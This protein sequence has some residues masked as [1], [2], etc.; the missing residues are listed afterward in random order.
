M[1]SILKTAVAVAALM[2]VAFAA[3][4]SAAT[5][6]AAPGGTGLDPCQSAAAPC[7]IFTA[8]ASTAPRTTVAAGDEVI[9]APGNYSDLAGDLGPQRF[10]GLKPGIAL[11]GLAGLPRPEIALDGQGSFGAIIV[12][13]GNSV[14]HLEFT[15]SNIAQ[16]AFTMEAGTVSDVIARS[17]APFGITCRQHGGTIR[18]SVC[19][20]SGFT[21]AAVGSEFSA[22]PGE[23]FTA[24]LRSVTAISTGPG[25][26]GVSYGVAGDA[27]FAID[28]IGVIARATAQDVIA[29]AF[30]VAP[31]TPGT[32]AGV[33]IALEHSAFGDSGTASDAGLGAPVVPLPGSGTNIAAAPLLA[34]DGYHQ[35]P[36]SPTVDSGGLDGFEIGHDIDGDSRTIGIAG[37]IGADELSGLETE[38]RLSCSPSGVTI[39]VAVAVTCTA[40]VA[41]TSPTPDSPTGNVR[42]DVD[43]L[44]GSFGGNATCALVAATAAES[45]C[46]VA[47]LPGQ[48]AAGAHALSAV[49]R[50]DLLHSSSLGTAVVMVA[51]PAGGGGMAMA[52]GPPARPAAPQTRL[53]KRPAAKTTRRLA[54]FSFASDQAGSR[55]ECRL[56]AKPFRPC[57]S[58]FRAKV[59]P[60]RHTFRVRAVSTAG[61]PDP[62]PALFGWK[63]LA[64]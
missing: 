53:T 38:T 44:S 45:S 21:G 1:T 31:R 8:A 2:A 17:S 56:D 18:D 62:T 25:G 7:S 13:A 5:R 19:L 23:A 54:A 40:T 9:L 14:S 20:A 60:G 10:V 39:G 52:P 30:S 63:V 43:P 57:R 12:G 3:D 46:E 36:G 29:R 27:E 55:F 42:F 41:D 26:R 4:A 64:R 47:Y 58:P 15:A 61:A 11:R 28:A 51:A 24:R 49:Y 32:G 59:S 35:L 16:A 22:E 48:V 33:E 34:A 37:D 6:F 50:G